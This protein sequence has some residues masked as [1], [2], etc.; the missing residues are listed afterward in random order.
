MCTGLWGNFLNIH[1]VKKKK[2]HSLIIYA[3]NASILEMRKLRNGGI[4]KA[5]F[6][7]QE[8]S[9]GLSDDQDRWD[10]SGDG[11]EAQEGRYVWI[12]IADSPPC[13][14]ETNAPL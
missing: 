10:R 9:S 12:L 1:C 7:S 6:K 5:I 13:T 4:F 3:D 2:A 11:T 14:A 8:L